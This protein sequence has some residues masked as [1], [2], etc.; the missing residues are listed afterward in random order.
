MLAHRDIDEKS[1]EIP[2]AQ[3]LLA[4]AAQEATAAGVEVTTK[5]L[6]GSPAE[7]LLAA[8]ADSG[9]IYLWRCRDFKRLF[10]LKGHN[11]WV[12]LVAFSPDGTLIASAGLALCS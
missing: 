4:E 12:R 11:D 5:I 9:E 1:N 7:T 8:G 3:A 10:T 6:E 2:A